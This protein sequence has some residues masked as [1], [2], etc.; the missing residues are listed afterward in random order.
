TDTAPNTI[1]R[2]TGMGFLKVNDTALL[3]PFVAQY[4]D[5][6]ARVWKARSFSIASALVTGYYPSPLFSQGLVD[7]TKA[8][9]DANPDEPAL[10][11]LVVEN[12]AGIE[13]ALT[14]QALDASAAQE[15]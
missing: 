2:A 1:V 13:R 6:I 7:A 12:L 11:R 4:F 8:W 9:L 14:A 15:G 10:R 5:S 3:D